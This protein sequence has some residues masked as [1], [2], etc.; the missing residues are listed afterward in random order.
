MLALSIASPTFA[1]TADGQIALYA[2]T[3][4]MSKPWFQTMDRVLFV[5]GMNTSGA[6]HAEHARALSLT[7]ACPVLG[8]YNRTDGPVSDFVQSLRD[9]LTLITATAASFDDW[10][11]VIDTNFDLAKRRNPALTKLDFVAGII[12][13]NRSTLALYHYL[14]ALTASQRQALRLYCHSQGNLI[15]ANALTA[16]ALALGKAAIAGIEVHC[17]GS[18]CWSWPPGL[19]RTNYGFTFDY[20]MLMTLSVDLSNVSIGFSVSHSFSQYRLHDAEFIVNRFRT[21][22]FGATLHM[23]EEALADFCVAL[24]GNLDRLRPIFER[25]KAAQWTD[26]DD[27]AEIYVRKMRTGRPDTLRQVARNDRSFVQLLLDCLTKGLLNWTTASEKAE[28]DF[29]K[30]LL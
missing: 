6:L 7:Q 20:V 14:A 25:L 9:K 26:C 12:G 4:A 3:E 5:N 30:T 18:P 19:R 21:G 2:S 11:R 28:A 10:A 29:L 8:I 22:G 16:L 1:P 17:F 15:A 24:G 27:V 23:D 13:G